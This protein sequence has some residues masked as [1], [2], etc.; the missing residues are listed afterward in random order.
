[1]TLVQEKFS[2]FAHSFFLPHQLFCSLSSLIGHHVP[3]SRPVSPSQSSCAPTT[4]LLVRRLQV[5]LSD[6]NLQSAP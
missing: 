4:P 2:V 5:S 1:M 6:G 3:S